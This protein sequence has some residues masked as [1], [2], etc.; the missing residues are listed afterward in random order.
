MLLT[1][2]NGVPWHFRTASLY[3][4][5]ASRAGLLIQLVPDHAAGLYRTHFPLFALTGPTAAYNERAHPQQGQVSQDNKEN[6]TQRS[7][8]CGVTLDFSSVHSYRKKAINFEEKWKLGSSPN[9]FY[10]FFFL[11]WIYFF[12]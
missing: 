6:E 5:A 3:S 7:P 1:K 10:I 12:F 11:F 8:F 2:G 4:Y 9:F